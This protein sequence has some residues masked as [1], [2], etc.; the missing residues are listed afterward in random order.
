M[1]KL[2]VGLK[3]RVAVEGYVTSCDKWIPTAYGVGYEI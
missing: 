3:V 1:W 2:N